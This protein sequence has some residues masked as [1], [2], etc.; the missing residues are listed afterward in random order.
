[1]TVSG[2]NRISIK[3]VTGV[4]YPISAN[5]DTDLTQPEWQLEM[6]WNGHMKWF[7]LLIIPIYF[8]SSI[9]P[10]LRL[11]TAIEKREWIEKKNSTERVQSLCGRFNVDRCATISLSSIRVFCWNVKIVSAHAN[12]SDERCRSLH[13]IRLN[14][15]LISSQCQALRSTLTWP[16]QSAWRSRYKKVL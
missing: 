2:N 6:K 16:D 10:S 8:T 7:H 5:R 12:K 14:H 4:F 11:I 13:I 3:P 9:G 15:T 1:M